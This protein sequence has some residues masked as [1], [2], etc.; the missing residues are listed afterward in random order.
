M[1]NTYKSRVAVYLR[2]SRNDDPDES[3]EETLEKHLN[4]LTEYA[5]KHGI[6][7]VETY[8]EVVSGD[9][10][11]TRPQMVRLLNDIEHGLY[12]AVMC[13]D[14]DR[15]GRS[16]TKDSGIILEVLRDN[17]C[18]IINPDKTYN[19]NDEVD[20][21]TVEMKTFVA[22]QELKSIKKR[23][24]RGQTETIKAGGHT[25]E[26]PYGYK[27]AWINKTPTLEPIPEKA[28][29]VKQI[30]DMYVNE[31]FGS[32]IIADKLNLMG[33]PAPDGGLW[34][35]SSVRM[36]ISNPLYAGLIIWNKTK[37]AKKKH[38]TDK[39]NKTK[40]PPELW[41]E[42]K[43]LHEALIPHD[44]WE[45]AQRIRSERSHPP[46]FTGVV[47]NPFSGLVH[48][49][50]CSSVLQRQVDRKTKDERLLCPTSGCMPSIKM[51]L[52]T[53]LLKVKMQDELDR[54][55][56]LEN[57]DKQQ[58]KQNH[59]ESRI[60]ALNKQ[61][62]T[63]RR[64]R[65]KLHDFLEQGVYDVDT[66]MKR[67]A[68]LIEKQNKTEKEMQNLHIKLRGAAAKI[69]IQDAIIGI[70]EVLH[71]WDNLEPIELNSALKRLIDRIS[72]RRESRSFTNTEF[73]IEVEW[74]F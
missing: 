13:M 32:Y 40:N 24:R 21:M 62:T 69:S 9:G 34:S 23:L 51:D 35:R 59:L 36:I 70:K 52:F 7:V 4:F 47:K 20:E 63:I 53:A 31:H 60:S 27:R 67:Q 61:L 73:E 58:I 42:A 54:L 5:L 68:V 38:P 28:E 18:R 1:D 45:E 14:I 39:I 2:K 46:S 48:C 65:D 33:V 50:N 22:R 55:L 74:K 12:T 10:L 19:L 3:V 29:I 37:T 64:Q 30:Y 57:S 43:G 71:E 56:I 17:D 49:S 6:T 11:F 41:I 25:G 8:K 72:Y 66:F 26:P 15:L 44:M 16:S